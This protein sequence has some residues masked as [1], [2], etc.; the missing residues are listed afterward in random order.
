M[1]NS[2]EKFLHQKDPKLHVSDFVEHEQS[3]KKRSSQE[4]SQKPVDKISDWLEVIEKTH[5]GHEDDPRVLE[6]LKDYYHNQHVIK[7][8]DVPESYF[9]NQRRL[10]REQGHGDVEVS[11]IDKQQLTEAIISDQRSTLDNWINY[12]TSSHSESFPTWSKHWSFN[13][14]LKL[15]NYD[16]EKHK[17]NKRSKDTVAPFPD[18]NREALAHV[19]NAIVKQVKDVKVKEAKDKQVKDEDTLDIQKDPEFEK[20]LQDANFAKLYAYAIEKVTPAK[21]SEL[22]STKGEWIKYD[23]DSD[24]MPLVNSIQGHGT[25]WCTAGEST[26]ESQLKN[27]DFFVYYSQDK[28]GDFKTPRAAI[29]MNGNDIAE[30]RGIAH[31]QNLDPYINDTVDE[32]LKDFPNG[33]AY[34]K[35]TAD[36]KRLTEIENILKKGREL[37][38]ND[39]RFLYQ[40]D[41]T[42]E[43][44]GYRDDPRIEEIIEERDKKSDLSQIFNIEK[45]KISITKNEAINNEDIVYHYGGLYLTGLTSLEGL[46]LPETVNGDL[47]LR[48]L[49]SAEGLRLPET[50]NGNLNL[51][52]LTSAEGL[53][54]PETVN[55]NL[56]LI[57]LTSAEG[58]KFPETVNGNL[59]LISLTSADGLN[60]PETVNGGLHLTGLTS[61]EGL[62][63]PETVNGFIYIGGLVEAEI[64]DLKKSDKV[65]MVKEG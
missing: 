37:D 20:L 34:K 49:T 57:S 1:E 64:S 9:E 63:L 33:E 39:L 53:K 42:I 56:N 2:G 36:M 45:N 19:V 47:D 58:L 12:Y 7:P 35:K 46:K 25:G 30:V 29:R 13:G 27:G 48:G 50:V 24:H 40:V 26:A 21:E 23:K 41:D 14:M 52:G 60:L 32:K 54:L 38:K 55:G 65:F 6:R 59:N 43:G 28:K 22:L 18:L 51:S 3:R 31:E 15:S 17:F 11:D 61:L 62:K 16:K 5:M 4:T 8:D 10:A 44:F